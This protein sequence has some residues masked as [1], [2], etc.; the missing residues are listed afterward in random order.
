MAF[1]RIAD[2]LKRFEATPSYKNLVEKK[3]F[4]W[5]QRKF[6]IKEGEVEFIFRHPILV[7]RTESML[8]KNSI[9]TSQQDLLKHLSEVCGSRFPKEM[10]FK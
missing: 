8:L 1:Q 4:E 5:C 7:V 3:A 9:F 2:F 6:A 10:Q